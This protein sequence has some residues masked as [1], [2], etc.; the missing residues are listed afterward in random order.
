VHVKRGK[1]PGGEGETSGWQTTGVQ[2]GPPKQQS[3]ARLCAV[4]GIPPPKLIELVSLVGQSSFV[5]H[6]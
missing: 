4:R 2:S 1:K 6:K 5:D 3:V